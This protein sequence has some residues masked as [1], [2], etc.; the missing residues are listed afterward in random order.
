MP[1]LF[2][3]LLHESML[4]SVSYSSP[5]TSLQRKFPISIRFLLFSVTF[6][7]CCI[8]SDSITLN[9]ILFHA[10]LFRT[11]SAS[12]NLFYS[13]WGFLLSNSHLSHSLPYLYPIITY[14]IHGHHDSSERNISLTP[15]QVC[16]WVL[17]T[18]LLLWLDLL[19]MMETNCSFVIFQA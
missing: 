18:F 11:T 12:A 15:S 7:S 10:P 4:L 14:V 8:I 6:I 17:L 16:E 3:M 9:S 1:Y 5:C 19:Y 13:H 2:S